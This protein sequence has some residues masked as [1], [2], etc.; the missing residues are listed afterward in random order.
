MMSSIVKYNW[1][2]SAIYALYSVLIVILFSPFHFIELSVGGLVLIAQFVLHFGLIFIAM[3]YFSLED[4]RKAL[5]FRTLSDLFVSIIVGLLI[6][7]LFGKSFEHSLVFMSTYIILPIPVIAL[8]V[9][10]FLLNDLKKKVRFETSSGE[11]TEEEVHLKIT[12]ESGK[13]LLNI[14]FSKVICFEAN[15]NYVVTYYLSSEGDLKKSMERIS[16]KKIEDLIREFDHGFYRVHKSFIVN[17]IFIEKITGRSQA[18]KLKILYLE[19]LVPV[20]RSFDIEL[21][22][23]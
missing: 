11:N 4:D 22:K 17:P 13:I 21:I 16:L 5:I 6:L 20:S 7:M 18:Y 10:D 1:Q 2:K 14:P 23:A 3:N 12:N 8:R 15:D 19:E 9:L